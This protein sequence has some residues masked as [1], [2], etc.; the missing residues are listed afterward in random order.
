VVVITPPPERGLPPDSPPQRYVE[1]IVGLP[2]EKVELV[3]KEVRINDAA[4]A[5]P[6]GLGPYESTPRFGPHTGCQGNPIRL[7]P[8][9]YFVLGDNSPISGDARHWDTPAAA[10]RQIGALP[11][12]NIN[13]VVTWTYWPPSRWKRI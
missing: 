6:A 10:G 3:G 9:E 11:A 13:G 7:G 2:G 4:V 5:L 8:D 1:R 12:T